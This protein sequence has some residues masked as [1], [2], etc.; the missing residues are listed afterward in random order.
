MSDSK[1]LIL[2][3]EISEKTGMRSFQCQIIEKDE[4]GKEVGKGPVEIHGIDHQSLKSTY[5][6]DYR[7]FLL[8]GVKPAMLQRYNEIKTAN[9][10]GDELA[11]QGL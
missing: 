1:L 7:R 10:H 11:G 2:R 9:S 8:E 4:D 3:T 5:G 6:G